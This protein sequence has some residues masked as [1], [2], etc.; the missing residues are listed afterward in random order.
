MDGELFAGLCKICWVHGTTALLHSC[1]VGC[2]VPHVHQCTP[3]RG[4]SVMQA[5]RQEN[6]MFRRT[7]CFKNLFSERIVLV[8]SSPCCGCLCS[9]WPLLWL[10]SCVDL[11]CGCVRE[12]ARSHCHCRQGLAWHSQHDW[13]GSEGRPPPC[14]ASVAPYRAMLYSCMHAMLA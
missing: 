10:L 2:V 9:W 1:I 11:C 12:C 3:F 4:I 5:G 7:G 14:T 6:W 8:L 13:D